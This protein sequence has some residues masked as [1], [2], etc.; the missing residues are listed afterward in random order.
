M[1][2]STKRGNFYGTE[3]L[4]ENKWKR[5]LKRK[6]KCETEIISSWL[7]VFRIVRACTFAILGGGCDLGGEM[8][9]ATQK[10]ISRKCD[11]TNYIYYETK[12]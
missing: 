9:K 3:Q 4:A 6:E 1:R 2:G 11:N 8:L 10:A 5:K 12:L 7:F